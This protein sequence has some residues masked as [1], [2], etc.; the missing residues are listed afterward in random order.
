[1]AQRNP[2]DDRPDASDLE[3]IGKS[4]AGF[5]AEM[6]A[7]DA[8]AAADTTPRA[9]AA[10]YDPESG[11]IIV[12]LDNDTAFIFPARLAQGVAGADPELIAK[13]QV[14]PAGTGLRWIELDADLGMKSL[15][16]GCFGSE[17]WMRQLQVESG[18]KGGAATSERKALAARANGKKGGRPRKQQA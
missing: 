16:M 6:A 11:R 17:M 8:Q 12:D 13:V 18:R 7:A 14:S 3:A 10:R 15:L 4:T 2:D 5:A 1:M 9:I